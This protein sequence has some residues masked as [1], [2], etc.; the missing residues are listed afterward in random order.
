M[1]SLRPCRLLAGP[2]QLAGLTV[3]YGTLHRHRRLTTT[4]T[5][6]LVEAARRGRSME[7]RARLPP[8]LQAAGA[9][10]R[11]P[12]LPLPAAL[13]GATNGGAHQLG[14]GWR[15]K[16]AALGAASQCRPLKCE[17]GRQS[18]SPP[19][20]G[21]IATDGCSSN[22]LDRSSEHAAPGRPPAAA[23]REQ[24]GTWVLE[25]RE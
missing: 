5:V 25:C 19:W 22:S 10:G 17:N 12:R 2:L 23:V 16:P 21:Q 1:S 6:P 14:G 4:P 8:E 18:F 3:A 9:C 20:R 15:S 24:Y 11:G 7:P 13:P